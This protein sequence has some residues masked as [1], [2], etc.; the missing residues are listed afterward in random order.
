MKFN[1][2]VTHRMT[3]LYRT[4]EPVER[5]G[6]TYRDYSDPT[7]IACTITLTA[8]GN[9]QLTADEELQQFGVIQGMRDSAG[10]VFMDTSWYTINRVTPT[11]DA[12]GYLASY[13]HQLAVADAE[14]I[15]RPITPPREFPWDQA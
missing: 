13:R 9:L 12:M 3:A 10:E 6:A 8:T 4:W 1:T 5:G 14:I 15:A 7:E 11:F 2:L